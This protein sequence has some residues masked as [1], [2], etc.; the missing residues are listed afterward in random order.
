MPRGVDLDA[1][2][3]MPL[4]AVKRVNEWRTCLRSTL[5]R[6]DQSDFTDAA[7][8]ASRCGRTAV[9]WNFRRFA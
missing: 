3:C 9:T 2:R 4:L 7:E 6:A 5:R 8:D 1:L